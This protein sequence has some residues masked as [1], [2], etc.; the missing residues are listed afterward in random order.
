MS[1]MLHLVVSGKHLPD[2]NSRFVVETDASG[3][4]LLAV[5]LRENDGR[6][7]LS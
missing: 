3:L 6:L 2:L 1:S 5:L 7:Q 4:G